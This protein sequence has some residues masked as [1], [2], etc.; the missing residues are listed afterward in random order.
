MVLLM[1]RDLSDECNFCLYHTD[2]PKGITDI[3]LINTSNETLNFDKGAI[4]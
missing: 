1:V 4:L 2:L 3:A